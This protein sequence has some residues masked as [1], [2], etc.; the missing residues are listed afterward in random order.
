MGLLDRLKS[1]AVE[2]AKTR[3]M[4]GSTGVPYEFAIVDV[5]TTGLDPRIERIIEVGIVIT[6]ANGRVVDEFCTL[7]QPE[8]E[9]D[10]GGRA[11]KVH[12]IETDWLK[13]APTTSMVLPQVAHRI[14]GRIIVAHNAKFDTEFLEEEFRRT[15][16]W[17]YDDL[18]D[19]STLCTVDLCRGLELPRKLDAAC[20]AVGIRY[21]KHNALGDCQATSQLLHTFMGKIDPSTFAGVTPTAIPHLPDL[22]PDYRPV[23]RDRAA[24]VTTARPVLE[25][26]VG[27]LPVHDGST[28]RDPASAD[29]YLVALEDAIA[30]GYISADEVNTLT[31]TAT[32]YGLTSDELR[33]L[34]QEVVLGLIDTALE[35]NRISKAERAEIEQ[36]ATWLSVDVSDWTAITKAA[37]ARIKAAVADFRDEMAD[38]RVAFTGTGIHKANFREALAAKHSFDYSTRVRGDTDLLVIGTESTEAKQV[39]MAQEI[40]IP[41]LVESTF[42]RQ[43]GEV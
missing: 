29:A 11:P 15:Y 8:G 3:V 22:H 16:G 43:L 17:S 24:E 12:L 5:E 30:D 27:M 14:N 2:K 10:F 34:H 7:V 4:A 26:L 28:D 21:E 41:I 36:L 19:W 31:V 20:R 33:D 1:K 6:D 23:L 35:D 37:R 9:V 25:N 38:K 32:R 39:E 13:A 42:W 40:G 18:G